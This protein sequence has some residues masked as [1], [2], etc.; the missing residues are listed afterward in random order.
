LPN[1]LE[2]K[3]KGWLKI[4]DLAKKAGVSIST[5]HYYV[6]E[7]LLT[8]PA[9]TSRNMAY[10]DPVCIEEIRVIQDHRST[11]FLPLS[12][13]KLLMKA[14]REGQKPEHV[15]EMRSFFEQIFHPLTSNDQFALLSREELLNRAGLAESSLRELEED[16]LISP[17]TTEGKAA[18]DDIDLSIAQ[19]AVKL[20]GFGVTPNDL[21]FYRQYL[22]FIVL[23]AVQLH[24]L[25]HRFP[26]HDKIS[27]SG[28][29]K[30]IRDLKE[31]L[32]IRI[33]R[34]EMVKMHM[35]LNDQREVKN[36]NPPS[37]QEP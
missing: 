10:Y 23:E 33:Y 5:I 15:G 14:E 1:N 20:S 21:R 17:R 7:G 27:M 2:L 8:S 9:R 36:E 18:Y 3:E 4:G 35:R 6:Q 12:V 29:F 32:S 24:D 22:E 13:I 16:G 30:T 37:S 34:Q 31:N 11:R 28:L 26:E 19:I 25:I